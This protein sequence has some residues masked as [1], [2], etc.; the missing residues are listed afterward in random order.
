[1]LDTSASSPARSRDAHPGAA[2]RPSWWSRAVPCGWC[3][4][5]VA[6]PLHPGRL[7]RRTSPTWRWTAGP[8]GRSRSSLS[9]PVRRGSPPSAGSAST[10]R[11]TP[12]SAAVCGAVDVLGRVRAVIDV[13]TNSVKFHIGERDAAGRWRAIVDRAELTCSASTSSRPNHSRPSCRSGR[14]PRSPAWPRRPDAIRCGDRRGRHSG[15]A[16][17]RQ[18]RRTSSR[19]SGNAPGRRHEVIL[20]RG[21]A[22]SPTWPCGPASA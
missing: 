22:G 19:P 1:M 5:Q 10:A 15:A 17:R 4:P 13:G 9:G 16:D 18:P 2:P 7:Q 12:A 8:R 3:G 21:G 14:W 20:W 11:P 6:C